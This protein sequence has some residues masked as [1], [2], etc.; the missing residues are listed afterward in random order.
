MLLHIFYPISLVFATVVIHS[1]AHMAVLR[2]VGGAIDHPRKRRGPLSATALIA[3]FVLSMS[4]IAVI[5]SA[6]WAGV[7]FAVGA[8]SDFRDALYFSL[9]TFTTLGYGD[10]T[11]NEEWR[12]LAGFQAAIGI[13][14]FGW[15][16]ALL[17]YVVQHTSVAVASNQT[18]V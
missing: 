4:L 13:I 6:M 3:A 12:L 10:I 9:V 11:L 7:Y 15:T 16:T 5:E 8:M 1:A 18:D 14:I 2:W 17:V